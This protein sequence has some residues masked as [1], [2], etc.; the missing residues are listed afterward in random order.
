MAES[1]TSRKWQR[2]KEIFEAALAQP[3]ERRNSFVTMACQGDAQLLAEVEN[4][5]AGDARLDSGFL[6]SLATSSLL[7][8]QPAGQP[9]FRE[10]QVISRRFE[11]LHFIGRGGMGEVYEAKDLDLHERVA[12]KVIRP[13]LSSDPVMLRRFRHEL[14]LARRVTH[15][16]VCRLHHL[17][18]C[19]LPASESPEA[20]PTITFITMELLE[21]ETLADRLKRLGRMSEIEAEPLITQ[22]ADGLAAA[23][24]AGV[25]HRDL[26]PGNIILV[27]A[28]G[29]TRAVITDFG[30]AR[31]AAGTS[32]LP[33]GD[34]SASV[35][36]GGFLVGTLQYMA[37][38]QLQGGKITAATDVYALGLV[39]Y[40]MLTGRNAFSR[41]PF[42]R[43]REGPSSP[44]QDVPGLSRRW[45]SVILRSLDR[46]QHQ[47]IAAHAGWRARPSD[48]RARDF[49]LR[50]QDIHDAAMAGVVPQ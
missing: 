48:P 49:P 5:L 8:E 32:L 17:E 46:G 31:V 15:P 16:N 27:N 1:L 29:K 28:S 26:K 2:A 21:G 18:S 14:Q 38:E 4:L 10:H 43:L 13:E 19:T 9:M 33:E 22:I 44:R 3:Q 12:L 7:A 23:H 35:S 42:V 6:N 30:L 50:A 11:I 37:P 24:Q 39:M 25:I 41:D 47:W 45:E 34:S 20:G 40:E 36:G